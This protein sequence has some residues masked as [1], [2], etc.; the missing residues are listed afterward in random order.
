VPLTSPVRVVKRGDDRLAG[1]NAVDVLVEDLRRTPHGARLSKRDLQDTGDG[2]RC[3]G[4]AGPDRA[5]GQRLVLP[6]TCGR[7]AADQHCMTSVDAELMTR[8]RDRDRRYAT[9]GAWGHSSAT[10]R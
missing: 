9:D 2:A 10:C 3:L 4:A 6:S 7:T 1:I 5:R 8:R